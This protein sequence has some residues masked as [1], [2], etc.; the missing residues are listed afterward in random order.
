ME[1]HE[2][3]RMKGLGSYLLQE[4]K[5]VCGQQEFIP[6]ARC[7][8]ENPA[9]RKALRKAGLK[10]VGFVLSGEVIHR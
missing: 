9:S 2:P 10:E 5:V 4:I 6:S 8:I 3:W 1:V 7:G